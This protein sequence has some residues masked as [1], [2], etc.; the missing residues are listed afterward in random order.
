MR[1][2]N[3]MGQ[4]R[5]SF[6]SRFLGSLQ[7][8]IFETNWSQWKPWNQSVHLQRK[9][10]AW[11]DWE[12]S[13]HLPA[14]LMLELLKK[15]SETES[16]NRRG[17]IIKIQQQQRKMRYQITDLTFTN[18][19]SQR[20]DCLMRFKPV[21]HPFPRAQWLSLGPVHTSHVLYH[22]AIPQ[23]SNWFSSSGYRWQ[24]PVFCSQALK[25]FLENKQTGFFRTS[26]WIPFQRLKLPNL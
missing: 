12:I 3:R 21:P 11:V 16:L 6:N 20:D 5:N 25:S 13:H 24:S 19:N 15:L 18:G 8:L 9:S 2:L 23:P 7:V 26:S 10:K 14:M 22:W 17:Q 4:E 1:L